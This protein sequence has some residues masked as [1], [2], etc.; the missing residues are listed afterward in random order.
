MLTTI[1]RSV[2]YTTSEIYSVGASD[3]EYNIV[4]F[5]GDTR[6]TIAD[7]VGN[8]PSP[9]KI[10]SLPGGYPHCSYISNTCGN[11]AGM[12]TCPAKSNVYG[13]G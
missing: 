1:M 5:P 8:R 6:Y 7:T 10:G 2:G 9:V 4:K 12:V 11:D 13:C 3:H